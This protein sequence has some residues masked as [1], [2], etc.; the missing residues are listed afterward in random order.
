MV[1]QRRIR[2]RNR[3]EQRAGVP[4]EPGYYK[5]TLERKARKAAGASGKTRKVPQKNSPKYH[6]KRAPK[7]RFP[8]GKYR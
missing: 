2:A 5:S 7:D 1:R 3:G 6:Q 8:E 4:G